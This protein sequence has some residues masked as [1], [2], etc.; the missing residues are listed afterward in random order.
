MIWY[1]LFLPLVNWLY[2]ELKYFECNNLK[3]NLLI[4]MTIFGVALFVA[5]SLYGLL[6]LI[7]AKTKKSTA[8][9]R[10]MMISA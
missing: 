4:N 2:P 8:H 6:S 3:A 10:H 1:F 9:I 7:F 5:L